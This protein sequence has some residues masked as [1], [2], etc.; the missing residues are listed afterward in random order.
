VAVVLH[1]HLR[2]LL[3]RRAVELHVLAAA[4]A[5]HAGRD[6]RLLLRLL[7]VLLLE[8]R[9]LRV[10]RALRHLLEAESETHSFMPD[11]IA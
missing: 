5:E 1:R 4:V 10:E 8:P 7:V 9:E 11:A 6:G 2:E 3:L